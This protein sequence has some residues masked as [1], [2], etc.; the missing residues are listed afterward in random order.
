MSILR[1]LENEYRNC[2][3][4]M[5][6]FFYFF[7][8]FSLMPMNNYMSEEVIPLKLEHERSEERELQDPYHY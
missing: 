3:S 8:F 6:T 1:H 7:L 2:F 4:E 5:Q